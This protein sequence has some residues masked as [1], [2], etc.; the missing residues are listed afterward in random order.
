MALQSPIDDKAYF[1]IQVLFSFDLLNPLFIIKL[2]GLE[3]ISYSNDFLVKLL[4]IQ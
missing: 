1:L 4:S 2:K 3:L